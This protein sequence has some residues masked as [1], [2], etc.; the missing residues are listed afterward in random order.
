MCISIS[1][2]RVQVGLPEELLTDLQVWRSV[3][4]PGESIGH[5]QRLESTHA[6]EVAAQ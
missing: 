3:R 6:H 1:R 4:D 5:T 2:L